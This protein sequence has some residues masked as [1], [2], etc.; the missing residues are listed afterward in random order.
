MDY[1]TLLN[2]GLIKRFT[3]SPPQAENRIELAKRDI[4]AAK[5]MM[6][7]DRDWA[8]SMAYNAILQA[9]RALMFAK[10]FRPAAGEGQHKVAVEF[11]EITLKEKFQDEIYIFDK[12]RSKRHRVIYDALGLISIAEAKQAFDF[13]VKFVKE[14]E[15]VLKPLLKSDL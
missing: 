8:F 1:E 14:I 4:K 15:N 5:S 13:S 10:G 7:I 3:S 12:M 2:K 6:S 11:A 9:T